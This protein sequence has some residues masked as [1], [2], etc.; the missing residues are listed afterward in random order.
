MNSSVIRRI[1]DILSIIHNNL[2]SSFNKDI[3]IENS[4]LGSKASLFGATALNIR[5]FLN[6][7]HLKI[8]NVE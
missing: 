4:R 3:A 1:P 2:E 8:I 7:S 5:N 6:I